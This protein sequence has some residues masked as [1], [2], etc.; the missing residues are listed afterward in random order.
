MRRLTWS[1]LLLSTSFLAAC[2]PL[3]EPSAPAPAASPSAAAPRQESGTPKP[4]GTLHYGLTLPVSGI[5]PH[6]N[7][8]SELGIALSSVYDTLV[9]Q[10]IEGTFHP[11]LAKSWQISPD[12]RTYTFKLRP[13][14]TFHDGTPFNAAAVMRNFQRVTDP[15][16]RSQKAVFLLGPFDHAEAVDETTVKLVL[17]EPY[18]PLLDGLSQVYLG[19]ASPAALDKWGDQ[20]QLH[21][22]GTGPFRFVEYQDRQSLTLERNENYRWAPSIYT[23]QGPAYL[24]RIEFRFYPDAATRLPALLSGQMDVIG[25]LPLTDAEKIAKAPGG[26]IGSASYRLYPIAVPGQSVQFFLNTSLAPLDDRRVRQALLHATDRAALVNAVFGSSSPVAAGPLSAVTRGADKG[27]SNLYPYDPEKARSLLSS[28]GWRDVNSDGILERDGTPLAL[29]GILMSWGDLPAIG[30][31]LQAQ[32]R[33]AGIDLQLDPLTYPAALEAGRAG[34]HHLMPFVRSGTDPQL[35]SDFFH[36]R[37]LNAFNFAK[38]SDPELDAWLD[39]AS[40]EGD[41]P[42]R[43]DLY[44]KVQQRIMDQAWILPVRDQV[45]LN[46][47]SSRVQDLSYDVQGWFPVLY[48][49]WLPAE[50]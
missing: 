39:E 5:D 13:D 12:G 21:Q 11:S 14:V 6:V 18:A 44:A 4:G 8:N 10:D 3:P 26:Q 32:W 31:I 48:D 37:N 38:V 35:L 17:R 42:K 20:Y 43:A 16:T 15:A 33:E 29:K 19:M 46:A 41:W 1:L 23:H 28:A 49:A 7:A 45:N 24:D 25:E 30:T 2:L 40:R 27:L 50:D 47:A 34:T 36:S 22:V 9:V